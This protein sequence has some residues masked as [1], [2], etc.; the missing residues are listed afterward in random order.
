MAQDLRQIIA[1]GG[2][3][4]VA[5]DALLHRYVVEQAA[6]SKPRVGYLGTASGD[7]AQYV[8]RFYEI[9][10]PLASKTSH[11]PLFAR[12]P[13]IEAYL[14]NIDVL[15][16]GG[17]NTKSMLGLF[18]EWN[19][20]SLLRTAW[21]SGTVIAGWSAGAI[22]WFESGISDS[23]ADALHP[24]PCLGFLPGSCCP[25][26][27]SESGRQEGY[28]QAV[29]SGRTE[30]GLGIH[31]GTAVHFVG[32]QIHEVVATRETSRVVRVERGTE[33]VNS[34]EVEVTLRL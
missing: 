21:M 28:A 3:S 24:I 29:E 9:Y 22:C 18:R 33:G 31:D 20:T 10:E 32:T 15:I 5:S 7:L 14:A 13:D 6:S 30:P 16:V 23:F 25:H 2:L 1:I 27:D 34:S 4:G 12:T 19:M 11:L 8:D 26:Y 17:G